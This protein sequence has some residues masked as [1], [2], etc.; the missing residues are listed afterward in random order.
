MAYIFGSQ[1]EEGMK[2]LKGLKSAPD[3]VSDL[4]VGL[5]PKK[6]PQH[7]YE[8]YGGLY[9]DLSSVFEPFKIDILFLHEVHSLLKFE[10]IKRHRIYASD[11]NFASDYE[12]AVL[13][14]ASDLAFKRKEFEKDFFEAIE[15][16]YFEIELK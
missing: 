5:L 1:Q 6:P 11:E 16:G 12:E 3:D 9:Y 10:V 13:K 2:F 14:T 15:H 4:D 7:M 8:Y